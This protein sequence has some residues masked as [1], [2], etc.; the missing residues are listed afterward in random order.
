M[1]FP[2]WKN[3]WSNGFDIFMR[4]RL[5]KIDAQSPSTELVLTS[6]NLFFIN[7]ACIILSYLKFLNCTD[8]HEDVVTGS[9]EDFHPRLR[10]RNHCMSKQDVKADPNYTWL[11]ATEYLYVIGLNKRAFFSRSQYGVNLLPLAWRLLSLFVVFVQ[12]FKYMWHL[13]KLNSD[14][15]FFYSDWIWTLLTV[16]HV[17]TKYT[18][19]YIF[20]F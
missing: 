13:R 16:I 11:V 2:C 15:T 14:M 5:F 6:G 20:L 10:S 3:R 4:M 18:K 8:A 7:C 19:Y 1:N 12:R 17:N 9:V